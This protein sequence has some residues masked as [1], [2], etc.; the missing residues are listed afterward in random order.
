MIEEAKTPSASTPRVE[1]PRRSFFKSAAA[2]TVGII[3]GAVPLAVGLLAFL[4]PLRRGS[5]GRNLVRVAPLDAVPEDG[6][7][8]LFRIIKDRV[9]A[10]TKYKNEPVGAVYLRRDQEGEIHAFSAVCPH[11]GCF[12]ALN[13]GSFRC[14]CHDSRFELDGSRINPETCPSPRD[15]DE[16]KVDQ[17][18]LAEANE[19]WVEYRNFVAGTPEKIDAETW[20]KVEEQV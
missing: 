14:P 16:L 9:D 7:P 1:P 10:W 12:V 2:M 5:G 11:L 3:A 6:N 13:D 8:A 15:L 19:V 18:K 17:E 4:D 20:E